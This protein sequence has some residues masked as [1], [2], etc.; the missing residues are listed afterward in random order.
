MSEIK[1]LDFLARNVGA[2]EIFTNGQ[3]SFVLLTGHSLGTVRFAN[4]SLILL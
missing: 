4:R 3:H 2:M 1:R